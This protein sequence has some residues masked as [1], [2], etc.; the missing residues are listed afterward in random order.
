M[1]FPGSSCKPAAAYVLGGSDLMYKEAIDT[2]GNS[3]FPAQLVEQLAGITLPV[4]RAYGSPQE[5]AAIAYQAG[6]Q[7]RFARKN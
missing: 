2:S 6:G 4:L 1:L 7:V 5:H 3:W